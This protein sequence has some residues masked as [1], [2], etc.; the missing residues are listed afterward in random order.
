MS[1]VLSKFAAVKFARIVASLV[2]VAAVAAVPAKHAYAQSGA[3]QLVAQTTVLRPGGNFTADFRVAGDSGSYTVD[4]QIFDRV[5]SR[6]AFARTLEPN[7]E[8]GVPIHEQGPTPVT[9]L[10]AGNSG[11]FTLRVDTHIA[12]NEPADPEAVSALISDRA[13]VY[14]VR[15]TLRDA[16]DTVIDELL[17]HLIVAPPDGEPGTFPFLVGIYVDLS[18]PTALQSDGA[19]VFDSAANDRIRLLAQA[20]ANAPRVDASIAPSPEFVHALTLAGEQGDADASELL[21]VLRTATT[22]REVVAGPY[23]QVDEEAWRVAQLGDRYRFLIDRGRQSLQTELQ[24]DDLPR[25][26]VRLLE[27][28]DTVQTIESLEEF[29]VRRFLAPPERVSDL[30]PDLFPIT[31]T[32]PFE[33]TSQADQRVGRATELDPAL[34]GYFGQ[35]SNAVLDAHHLLADLTVLALDRPGLERG[36]ILAPPADWQPDAEFLTIVLRG[37][38]RSPQLASA[39]VSD[40]FGSIGPAAAD[41]SVLSGTVAGTEPL[42]REL[43]GDL[44]APDG[45]ANYQADLFAAA[46]VLRSYEA[47]VTPSDAIAPLDQLLLVSAAGDLTEAERAA[48]LE[49]VTDSV[50][51]IRN[52]VIGPAPQVI[53]ITARDFDIPFTVENTLDFPVN[54]VLLLESDKL[55]F[56]DGAEI[57]K[58][59][60]PGVNRLEVAVHT[61]TTGDSVLQVTVRSPD[62]TLQLGLPARIT[63]RSTVFSGLGIVISVVALLV[64][65]TW[66]ARQFWAHRKTGRMVAPAPTDA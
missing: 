2:L 27:P 42:R 64:L 20:F 32:Q 65:M 14:P 47:V 15:L 21:S 48:Y 57:T 8:L 51:S 40:Y 63:V 43:E 54:A 62:Q 39:S 45:M 22:G 33:L 31:L 37:L 9:E 38:G 52:S 59:L 4:A 18:A 50:R 11:L 1:T 10:R 35:S 12:G 56:P 13:G 60:A 41:G 30:D 6:I 25:S 44:R 61:K 29:G 28:T 53:S 26:T 23:V 19:I 7:A 16:D 5:T 3:I 34:H 36:T 46:A 49:A 58:R 17:S 66:W 55:E 24:L